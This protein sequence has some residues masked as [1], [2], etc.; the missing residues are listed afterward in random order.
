MEAQIRE[1]RKIIMS[2]QEALSDFKKGVVAKLT[3]EDAALM[4][5]GAEDLIRSGIL[6]RAKKKGDVAPD[7][8]LPNPSGE[9]VAL[10]T[11]LARGPV[12]VTFYRGVW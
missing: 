4:D 2:L 11:L 6:E 1:K 10:S 8:A 9:M 3:P 5:Q 12:V 7:F